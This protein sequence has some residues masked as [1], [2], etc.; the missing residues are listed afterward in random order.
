MRWIGGFPLWQLRGDDE[1]TWA[2]ICAEGGRFGASV[3]AAK[4]GQFDTIWAAKVAIENGLQNHVVAH[5]IAPS[6][7]QP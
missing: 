6:A 5:A 2:M 4:L 1:T 7:A 3:G